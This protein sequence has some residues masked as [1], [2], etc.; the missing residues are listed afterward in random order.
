MKTLLTGALMLLF[1]LPSFA[2]TT[3][4]TSDGYR[5]F[6]VA[7]NPTARQITKLFIET[8]E[9]IHDPFMVLRKV[10]SM[11]NQVVP[12][13]KTFLF[14]TP[15]IKIAVSD[16]NGKIDSINTTKPDKRLGLMALDLIGTP[17]AYQVIAT[18]AQSDSN[19]ELKA[20]ALRSLALNYYHKAK[21][22]SLTPDPAV[23]GILIDN[24]D[25]TSYVNQLG[26]RVGQIARDGL[27]RWTGVDYGEIPSSKVRDNEEKRIGMSLSQ[28]HDN[29]WKQNSSKMKWN[30][31]KARFEVQ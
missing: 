22:D 29:W 6:T 26:C 15:V 16:P 11:G 5:P 8:T 13:L 17:E 2:G 31:K 10:G 23:V 28:Y 25:D 18:A 30:G 7:A 1:A 3:G 27:K 9:G 14:D 21:E 12:A 24:M 20:L 4:T 19:V